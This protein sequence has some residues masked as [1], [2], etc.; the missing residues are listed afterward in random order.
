MKKEFMFL[1]GTQSI[2]HTEMR[3]ERKHHK[4][5]K[6]E[7]WTWLFPNL[8]SYC[9]ASQKIS[10]TRKYDDV[11]M[12]SCLAYSILAAVSPTVNSFLSC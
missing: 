4:N 2:I 5:P 11:E 6:W 7:N 10:E 9:W 12:G 8:Y 1:F 3:S